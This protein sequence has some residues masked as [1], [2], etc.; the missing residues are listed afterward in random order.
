MMRVGQLF[1]AGDAFFVG[2]QLAARLKL[3][4][5]C[6]IPL[7]KSLDPPLCSNWYTCKCMHSFAD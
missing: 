7:L 3:Q 4:F 6:G 2:L 5:Q 1:S